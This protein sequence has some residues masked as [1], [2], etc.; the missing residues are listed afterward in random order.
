VSDEKSERVR[1]W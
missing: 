1:K